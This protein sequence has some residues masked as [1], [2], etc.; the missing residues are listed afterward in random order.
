MYID[1]MNTAQKL[2]QYRIQ[3]RHLGGLST[4]EGPQQIYIEGAIQP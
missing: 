1:T 3:E 2:G 4:H